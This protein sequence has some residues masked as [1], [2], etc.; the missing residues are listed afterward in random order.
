MI[1]CSKYLLMNWC[2]WKWSE[3]WKVNWWILLVN[4]ICGRHFSVHPFY[5]FFSSYVGS[6]SQFKNVSTGLLRVSFSGLTFD[7][8]QPQRHDA[9]I[10]SAKHSGYVLVL[11]RCLLQSN[12]VTVVYFFVWWSNGSAKLLPHQHVSNELLHI[13]V[14][15]FFHLAVHD[16]WWDLCYCQNEYALNWFGK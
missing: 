5:W 4:V 3:N 7:V 10:W 2:I 1:V 8:A 16:D 6:I 13:P 14:E 11:H 12:V 9:L 15:G